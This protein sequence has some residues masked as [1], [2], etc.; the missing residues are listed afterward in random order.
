[1]ADLPRAAMLDALRRFESLPHRMQQLGY[2]REV[3]WI[4][5]SKAT[6]VAATVAAL[7]S[8]YRPCLWIAGGAGKRADFSD[9]RQAV[10]GCVQQAFFIGADAAALRSATEDVIATEIVDDLEQAVQRAAAQ[11]RSGDCVLLSPACSS[12]DC[13][14]N[15]KQRGNH[16]MKLFSELKP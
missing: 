8:L 9:L 2:Y 7:Q 12:L 4:N 10:Q 5:D 14:Q 3:L 15:Y 11:G 1:M 13:Y 6:N 16:F